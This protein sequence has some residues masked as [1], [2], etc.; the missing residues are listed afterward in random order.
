MQPLF[1]AATN[2][3]I[4]D[5]LK[6]PGHALLVTGPSG[7]GKGFTAS[8]IVSKLLGSTPEKIPDHPY[9]RWIH[10]LD[11]AVSIEDIRTAQSLMQLRVPGKESIRRALIVEQG[12]TM[13]QEAQNAFLKLLEEPPADTVIVITVTGPEAVLPTIRSRTQVLKILPPT[14]QQLQEYFLASHTPGAI[15]KAYYLSEGYI[16]LMQALLEKDTDHPLVELIGTAKTLLGSTLYERL[17]KVD[18]L[19]K[20]KNTQLLLQ[21]MERVCHAALSQAIA[22]ENPAAKRWTA[23]LQAIVDAR[24]AASTS[25]QTKLLLT[26]LMLGL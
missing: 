17:S 12:E 15:T 4:Q 2:Q 10:D 13:S 20:Q 3:S 25:V 1:H 26:N 5:F 23:R 24:T 19:S 9:V 21:A 6:N 11:K 22:S 8:Y 18:E 14:E 7:A 16:G